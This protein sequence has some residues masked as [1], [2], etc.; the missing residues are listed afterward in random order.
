MSAEGVR[1]TILRRLAVHFKPPHPLDSDSGRRWATDYVV[2]MERYSNKVAE[3]ACND[4]LRNWKYNSFPT[5]AAIVES[6]ERQVDA[7]E[8]PREIAPPPPGKF[9]RPGADAAMLEFVAA[10]R[11][12]Q[13]GAG[14]TFKGMD[15]SAS[16]LRSWGEL[17]MTI[18][19]RA[20]R[21]SADYA[22]LAEERGL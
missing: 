14:M 20:K 4:V 8:R 16:T 22:R 9:V 12:R 13:P 18:H 19:E 5:I 17:G 2:A 3:M 21:E 15:L 10:Y 6:C 1:D 7:R 11:D